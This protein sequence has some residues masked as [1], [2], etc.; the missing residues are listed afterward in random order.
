MATVDGFQH[1]YSSVGPQVQSTPDVL[2]LCHNHVC[3]KAPLSGRVS[4]QKSC[5][6]LLPERGAI[7]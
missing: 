1:N 4:G 3:S 6:P 5:F 7:K 2:D